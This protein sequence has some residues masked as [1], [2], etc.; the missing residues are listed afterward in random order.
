MNTANIVPRKTTDLDIVRKNPRLFTWGTVVKIHD[1]G[2]SY[3]V[4]EYQ[5]HRDTRFHVYVDGQCTSNSCHTLEGALLLAIEGALLLAIGRKH[6]EVNEAR[7]MAMA[8]T[9]LLGIKES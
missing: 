2:S 3:T 9:K 5:H 1:V 4:I 8:A 6:L 7:F